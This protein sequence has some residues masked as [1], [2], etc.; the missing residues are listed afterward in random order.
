MLYSIPVAGVHRAGL[1]AS[2]AGKSKAAGCPVT[3]AIATVQPQRRADFALQLRDLLMPEATHRQYP[4]TIATLNLTGD[5][6][7]PRQRGV[8]K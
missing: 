6:I 3:V 1:P 5:K 7:N 8:S 4:T 2:D